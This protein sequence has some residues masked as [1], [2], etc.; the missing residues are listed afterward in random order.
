MQ[1]YEIVILFNSNKNNK[2]LEIIKYYIDYIKKKGG[3]IF[4]IEDWGNRKLSYKIK[5]HI[6]AHYILLNIQIS[7]QNIQK[8]EN[9][10]KF[11]NLIIRKLIIRIKKIVNNNSPMIKNKYKNENIKKKHLI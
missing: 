8:I 2:I 4:K 6:K 11:N 3:Q 9:K 7:K 5:K 1:N 10:L